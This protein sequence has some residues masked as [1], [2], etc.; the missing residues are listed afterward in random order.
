[1]ISIGETW[2]TE[3]EGR[4]ARR[5][6]RL[7]FERE[8]DEWFFHYESKE[9]LDVLGVLEE[10]HLVCKGSPWAWCVEWTWLSWPCPPEN[11]RFIDKA[12]GD[13]FTGEELEVMWAEWENSD[14][15]T[16]LLADV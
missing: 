10:V 14:A 12:T 11:S 7:R 13:T 16:A 3:I 2:F 8:N 4:D 15:R 6:R 9:M 1:M 5:I